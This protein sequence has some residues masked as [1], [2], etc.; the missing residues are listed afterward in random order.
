MGEPIQPYGRGVKRKGSE[1]SV[2][3]PK[4]A[5]S[6]KNWLTPSLSQKPAKKAPPPS[7][8]GQPKP[9]QKQLSVKDMLGVL[10]CNPK[11]K[12][13]QAGT[14]KPSQ[15]KC[16]ENVNGYDI[17]EQPQPM[18]RVEGVKVRN[19]RQKE[20]KMCDLSQFFQGQ[21]N[22]MGSTKAKPDESDKEL[23]QPRTYIPELDLNQHL[24][25]DQ[26]KG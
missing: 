16:D 13:S 4:H 8:G 19:Q 21:T 9:R 26:S 3:Q 2:N 25:S 22:C 12:L 18:K 1:E 5:V 11:P 17:H 15:V 6:T 10:K 24:H 7:Q 20:V 23:P 14:K